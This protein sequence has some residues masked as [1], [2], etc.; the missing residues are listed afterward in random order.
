[1]LHAEGMMALY[2]KDID[3]K[4]LK[5]MVY[6]GVDPSLRRTGLAFETED[7]LVLACVVVPP[8]G[9]DK[10]PARLGYLFDTMT[11]IIQNSQIKCAAIEGYSFG[12]QWTREALGEVGGMYRLALFKAGVPT[13]VVQ[14]TSVKK[15]LTNSGGSGKVDMIAGVKTSYGITV[16]D[17]NEAD[18]VVLSQIANGAHNRNI[19]E[20]HRK[21]VLDSLTWIV[22]RSSPPP[23]PRMRKIGET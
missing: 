23:R 1:M 4:F 18:A 8:P 21:E 10:G 7:G 17:D 13:V 5:G 3:P 12:S 2:F 9:C 14:P 6:L 16:S 15:F 11:G 22:P 20:F 19:S